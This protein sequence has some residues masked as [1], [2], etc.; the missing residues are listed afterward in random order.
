MVFTINLKVLTF[1]GINKWNEIYAN[2]MVNEIIISST[3]LSY[4]DDFNNKNK[5]AKHDKTQPL[6][7]FSDQKHMLPFTYKQ[8][9]GNRCTW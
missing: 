4:V 6:K 9:K 5:K 2:S 8:T 1:S 3:I 7:E